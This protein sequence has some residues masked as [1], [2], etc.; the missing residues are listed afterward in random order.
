M[1]VR[2]VKSLARGHTA[3]ELGFQVLRFSNLHRGP[4][5]PQHHFRLVTLCGEAVSISRCVST[6]TQEHTA[7]VALHSRAGAGEDVEGIS[8]RSSWSREHLRV[9]CCPIPWVSTGSASSR[10]RLDRHGP[11]LLALPAL[12]W[13]LPSAHPLPLSQWLGLQGREK[14]TCVGKIPEI[15]FCYSPIK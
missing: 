7:D 9:P 5:P 1:E 15:P 6:H 12:P 3:V 10:R 13:L 11:S 14:G 4:H 2:E 8:P